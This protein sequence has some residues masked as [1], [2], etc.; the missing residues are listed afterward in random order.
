MTAAIGHPTLRLL[1]VKMGGLELG[2]LRPGEWREVGA[3]QRAVL[4]QD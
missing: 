3:A 2:A 4:F 1:R